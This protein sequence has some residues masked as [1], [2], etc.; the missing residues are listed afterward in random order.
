LTAILLC[1]E[2]DVLGIDS[3][4]PRRRRTMATKSLMHGLR[5]TRL[6]LPIAFLAAAAIAGCTGMGESR[7]REHGGE[8][9]EEESG[10]LLGL[11]EEFD[12]TRRGARLILRYDAAADAFVGNVANTTGATLPAVRVEAHL[13]NGT[14]LGPTTPQDLAPGQTIPVTLRAN[15]EKFDGWIAHAEVGGGGTEGEHGG[16][17]AGGGEHGSGGERSGEHGER[18]G[19]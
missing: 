8:S 15:A 18:G 5:F 7:E 10:T 19:G 14:E 3:G 1:N 4:D 13:S 6:T 16:G 17:G 12:Q 9:G 11:D 2:T